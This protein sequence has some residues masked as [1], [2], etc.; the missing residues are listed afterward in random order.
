M[1]YENKINWVA[2]A[3]GGGILQF[4]L[5]QFKAAVL[6]YQ[7]E[8]EGELGDI[9]K[10]HFQDQEEYETRYIPFDRRVALVRALI[11]KTPNDDIWLL[12][13]SLGKLRNLYSHS[14]FTWTEA[15]KKEIQKMTNTMLSQINGIR[16]DMNFD[17]IPDREIQVIIQAHFIV[18]RFLR[19]I[20]EAL[21]KLGFAKVT[22]D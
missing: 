22:S 15:G 5:D 2:P 14:R 19:E 8:V 16:P 4:T 21:D 17:P 7:V 6:D 13:K 10:R 9:I 11:G 20:N 12:V 1:L 18:Q 3:K